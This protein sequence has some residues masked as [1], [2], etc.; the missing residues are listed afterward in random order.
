MYQI[1]ITSPLCGKVY[2]DLITILI[3]RSDSFLFHLPNMGKVLI[4]E[5]NAEFMP[6]YPLG[7]TEEEDQELHKLY[8][9]RMEQYLDIIQNDIIESHI[10]TGYLDQVS[11]IEIKVFNV[12]ISNKT[13]SFFRKTDDFSKWKYPDMPENPCFLLKG[14]CLFQCIAHENICFLNFYDPKIIKL[15]KANKIKFFKSE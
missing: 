15:F 12:S 1:V 10:D 9:K 4:N 7:Y 8:I 3:Q 5:R 2:Q 14:E 13:I 6:E 11:N